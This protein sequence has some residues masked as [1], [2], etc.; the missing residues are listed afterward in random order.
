MPSRDDALSAITLNVSATLTNLCGDYDTQIAALTADRDAVAAVLARVQAEYDQYR[1]DNP[2]PAPPVPSLVEQVAGTWVLL[3]VASVAELD[4]QR[5]QILNALALPGVVGFSVRFPWDAC[6]ITGTATSH[7]ILVA[8]KAIADQ[9]G[10]ALSI[11]FMAG[12]HTPARVFDAGAA[13]YPKGSSKVPLPWDNSTG[14]VQVFL[15]EYATYAGKLAAWA[16]ANGVRLLHFSWF[17]QDWAELN[18]GK[19]LR[20]AEGY[21]EAKWLAGQKAVIDVAASL[22]GPDLAVELPL[23]GYGPLSN[24]QSAALADYILGIVGDGSDQFFVQANGLGPNGEWGGTAAV[25]TQQDTIWSKPI[26]RGVQMIQ[27]QDYDWPAV[28]AHVAAAAATYVEVY[29]PSFTLES[30]SQLRQQVAEFATTN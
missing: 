15:D 4:K 20:A 25:E 23:S 3:Q 9:A 10:K 28:F 7:P 16:R 12:A 27:P 6:D 2:P 11:R 13:Y 5:T 26:N 19:E 17:G 21:S 29:L 14:R 18:H 22:R 1:L 30:A 8:A 24:G